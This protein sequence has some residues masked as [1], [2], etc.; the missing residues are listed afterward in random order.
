MSLKNLDTQ[1]LVSYL[2]S[3]SPP[4]HL[5]L[6]YGAPSELEDL[7]QKIGAHEYPCLTVPPRGQPN[8]KVLPD[9]LKKLNGWAL[10]CVRGEEFTNPGRLIRT[11]RRL[12]E[13]RVLRRVM[14]AYPIEPF[15]GLGEDACIDILSLHHYVIFSR[16][17]KGGLIFL[18]SAGAAISDALG[19]RGAEMIHNYLE[20][21]GVER[22]MI[23]LKLPRYAELLHELLGTGA[24]PL[25]RITYRNLFQ[26]LRSSPE[27]FRDESRG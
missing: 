19:R 8:L 4:T 12:Q 13:R 27:M 1:R 5:I 3:L 24:T 17:S 23:P 2:R 22:C 11:E 18:E 15:I 20:Q 9:E 10:R 26:R 6:L 14:C 21:K 16:F 7:K 25:M